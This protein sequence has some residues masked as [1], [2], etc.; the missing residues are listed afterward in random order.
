MINGFAISSRIRT[1]QK[2]IHRIS[3][4][5]ERLSYIIEES[6]DLFGAS[7]GSLSIANPQEK[8]LTIVAAK[9]MDWEKK[10][11]AKLPFSMG[12][13]GRAA[14]LQEIVYVPNVLKD[15]TYVRLI[16]SVRSELAIPLVTRK[17]TIGVL[18]L[19]SDKVDFFKPE[20]IDAANLFASQLTIILLE[21]RIASEAVAKHKVDEDPVEE[22][23]GYDPQI[24]FLKN[25]I[26]Q[27]AP[28]DIPV[29]I[30]GEEGVGKRLVAKAIHYISSRKSKSF[31]SLDCAGLSSESLEKELFGRS[32]TREQADGGTVYLES[33]GNLQPEL[34]AKLLEMISDRKTNES[35]STLGQFRLIAG[36]NSDLLGDLQ[37]NKFSME[38]YY[39]LAESPI[40]VPPI[41]DRRG[42]IPLLVQHFLW[43][44]NR[45]Y[46]RS[47]TI[48]A[49]G[50]K[51]L[52]TQSWLGN[53][54]QLQKTIQYGV[55]VSKDQDLSPASFQADPIG[56]ENGDKSIGSIT[57]L[58]TGLTPGEDLS[59]NRAVE[60]L[61]AIWI[62]EAFVRG[63]TQ[64]EAS[65]LLGISRGA[66]QYKIRNNPFLGN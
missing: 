29:L 64:E 27:L 15:P 33:I 4:V 18:N 14:S 26:R 48:S 24:L 31:L 6:L 63:V 62:Q 47:K 37:T 44:Y 38:L 50:M 10:M 51:Y 20:I 41:R 66:L 49:E 28:M 25:R 32:G 52:V 23:L 5:T 2:K 42:D 53:V 36:S 21:E 9:G 43:F 58:S 11:A 35:D 56:N 40:R 7:T 59:L 17:E 39:K 60:K 19:E 3:S 54:S 34:Q 45:Q 61:E 57:N 65:K 1:L 8:V 46:E 30:L 22:L 12:I 55:L 16:D 13:T